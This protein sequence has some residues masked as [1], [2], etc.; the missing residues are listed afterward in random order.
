MSHVLRSGILSVLTAILTLL[1]SHT[2]W[3][4][5]ATVN[6][7]LL[8]IPAVSSGNEIL[9]LV[10][11]VQQ[12]TDPLQL[13]IAERKVASATNS[14]DL[15]IFDGSI[16]AIPVVLVG[17][18]RYR[19]NLIVLTPDLLAVQDVELLSDEDQSQSCQRPEPDPSHGSNNPQIT[20]DGLMVL[21]AEIFDGGPGIDGI[22]AISA[23]RFSH[24]SKQPQLLNEDLGVGVKIG[25]QVRAYPHS[26][27]DWH[28]IVNDQFVI[29]GLGES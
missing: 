18:A 9:E 16:L 5:P 21:P 11:E 29:D 27:L 1:S 24:P 15:A 17:G 3:A 8:T 26:I 22:P 19:V 6:G 20:S 25:N 12:G 13:H 7:N 2:V 28:E 4:Q 10:L 23:P 14:T